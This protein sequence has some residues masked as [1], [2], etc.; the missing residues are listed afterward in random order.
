MSTD[1]E[2]PAGVPTAPVEP[3]EGDAPALSVLDA[4][5]IRLQIITPDGDE[6]WLDGISSAECILAIRSAIAEQPKAAHFTAYSLVIEPPDKDTLAA[7]VKAIEVAAAGV[8]SPSGAM[9]ISL[10]PGIIE[11][12]AHAKALAGSLAANQAGEKAPLVIELN[13]VLELSEYAAVGLRDGTTVRM[14]RTVYDIRAARDHVRRFR[15]LLTFPPAASEREAPSTVKNHETKAEEENDLNAKTENNNGDGKV[16]EMLNGVG[17]KSLK[18]QQE[19][20]VV[21]QKERQ[22]ALE[23]ARSSLP[24][25][26]PLK[27]S[28]AEKLS[29][30]GV[31]AAQGD[32]VPEELFKDIATKSAVS[33]AP[34]NAGHPS[35]ALSAT[36]AA[37]MGDVEDVLQAS[38]EHM[39]MG[40]GYGGLDLFF[41]KVLG[42]AALDLKQTDKHTP[43]YGASLNGSAASTETAATSPTS[44]PADEQLGSDGT[45]DEGETT[46]KCI[47][48]M[49]SSGWNPPPP[50]R[51]LLGD[52]LYMEVGLL[53]EECDEKG[54]M[55]H[56]TVQLTATSRG[57]YVNA[58]TSGNRNGRAPQFRPE[59]KFTSDGRPVASPELL[60]VL[61][62]ASPVCAKRWKLLLERAK[63]KSLLHESPLEM[64]ALMVTEG[65]MDSVIIRPQWCIPPTPPRLDYPPSSGKTEGE[66]MCAESSTTGSDSTEGRGVEWSMDLNRAEE[67]LSA[68]LPW[69]MDER[70]A[71][72]DWNEE[73]QC[74][75]ELPTRTLSE[76]LNRAK[77]V[78]KVWLDFQEAAMNGAAAISAG[79]VPPINPTE[80][81]RQHVYVFNNLFFSYGVDSKDAYKVLG[82]DGAAVKSARHDLRNVQLLDYY[83]RTIGLGTVDKEKD[84]VTPPT[85][86]FAEPGTV[87]PDERL[88][89]LATAIVDLPCAGKRLVAQSIIPGILQGDQ[90]S[91]LVYGAIEHGV[92]YK[93]DPGMKNL[94]DEV[95]SKLYIAPRTIAAIPMPAAK[96]D[97][98]Q[99]GQLNGVDSV[100]KDEEEEEVVGICNAVELKGICGSDGRKYALDILRLTPRD[101]NWLPK[102]S[103][104]TGVFEEEDE[105]S[106]EK[107]TGTETTASSHTLPPIENDHVALLRPE[108]VQHWF[109]WKSQVKICVRK[110]QGLIETDGSR[111][112]EEGLNPNVFMP[113]ACS[114]DPA[115]VTRDEEK[116][117]EV[118]R[119]LVDRVLPTITNEVRMGNIVPCD[120]SVLVD[121]LHGFGVNMRYL[122]RLADMAKV[123][124][125]RD[126]EENC[127][128]T[129]HRFPLYWRRLLEIEMVTRAAK[130]VLNELLSPPERSD[131]RRAPATGIIT[132]LNC[133]FGTPAQTVGVTKPVRESC[134]HPKAPKKDK[135][136]RRGRKHNNPHARH[137]DG[138]AGASGGGG[139]PTDMDNR[140][141]PS[142]PLSADIIALHAMAQAVVEPPM[143][144]G[145]THESLWTIIGEHVRRRF[146]YH[147]TLW[148]VPGPLAL[149]EEEQT[150]SSQEIPGERNAYKPCLL[151]RLCSRLGLRI[152]AKRYDWSQPS[153]FVLGD[154]I[155]ALPVSKGS[156]GSSAPGWTQGIGWLGTAGTNDKQQSPPQDS[157][158]ASTKSEESVASP[159]QNVKVD[160]SSEPQKPDIE[161]ERTLKQRA[162]QTVPCIPIPPFGCG[163]G[164]GAGG[165]SCLPACPLA[166]IDELLVLAQFQSQM[167]HWP[168][169]YE[170]AQ[171]AFGLTQA[172]CGPLHRYVA[173]ALELLAN[174]LLQFGDVE[175]AVQ[176]QSKALAIHEQLGGFDTADVAAAHMQLAMY[177]RRAGHSDFSTRTGATERRVSAQ[178]SVESAA[179][180]ARHMAAAAYLYD[181]MGGP[182]HPEAASAYS[183]LGQMYHELCVNWSAPLAVAALRCY[184]DSLRRANARPITHHQKSSTSDKITETKQN[185]ND[186]KVQAGPTHVQ[187]DCLEKVLQAQTL[188]NMAMLLGHHL[189]LFK[190]ALVYEKRCFALYRV[191]LGDSHH[192]TMTSSAYLKRFTEHAVDQTTKQRQ[193][194]LDQSV[195]EAAAGHMK[196]TKG[197]VASPEVSPAEAPPGSTEVQVKKKSKSK[198]RKP[199]K[200]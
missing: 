39:T 84:D 63:S 96:D 60:G 148:P 21:A 126:L 17:H 142:S 6:I 72:R 108:L 27:W 191:I 158:V 140:A 134:D 50:E 38:A 52:L 111:I 75:H 110:M 87:S 152:T 2:S 168:A 40:L 118:S 83:Q 24:K 73:Y 64:L 29:S 78:Y 65:R 176:Q 74:V 53:D 150:K 33:G 7:A 117:R 125:A 169:V 189:G 46:V 102:A 138:S 48:Y 184:S 192:L 11:N 1:P 71:L 188:H 12:R 28:L 20:A 61:I 70:G 165:H 93:V 41:P 166:D 22:T 85:G 90:L 113:F 55:T 8:V 34:S 194:Q 174:A 99:S 9:P 183:K 76:K 171:Q 86:C 114:A 187:G 180:A 57:W 163:T 200:K 155:D 92:K 101:A 44:L 131:L 144:L 105:D 45:S 153:P 121:V 89:T 141:N 54:E 175:T 130:H 18:Q 173:I 160:G 32:A 170:L 66:G 135:R 98:I 119:W 186:K 19:A 145:V 37:V 59:P 107:Q 10:G 112:K 193:F 197:K 162:E 69:G 179:R 31:A 36:V 106:D 14:V 199:K 156:G 94:L 80:P 82:G 42:P 128:E 181:L 47:R 167:G 16:A 35:D 25:L 185:L 100:D 159:T 49:C 116:V 68:N 109:A 139:R 132:F 151:R 137:S 56:Q 195:F 178:S 122:G 91:K 149:P 172:V 77:M 62:Q 4:A 129:H 161:D 127:D 190:E 43:H 164:T 13:D 81:T 124:E 120:S 15:E 58:S 196:L 198:R 147:L 79:H 146:R 143:S 23:L 133:I 30:A 136:S 177:L 88:C 104:G 157:S 103:G 154:V 97:P 67:D 115:T 5:V 182:L 26:E 3:N 123:E 51:R 95:A